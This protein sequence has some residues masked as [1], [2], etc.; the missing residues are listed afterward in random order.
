MERPAGFT[1]EGPAEMYH[2]L[3]T[4]NRMVHTT[5]E[6]TVSYRNH[7]GLEITYPVK[8]IYYS[9]PHGTADNHFSGEAIMNYAGGLGFGLTVTCRRDRFPNGLKPFLHHEKTAPKDQRAKC[10][11]FGKLIVFVKHRWKRL[12]H[13]RHINT[14]M[15]LFS[16]LV[17]PTFLASIIYR[18][19]S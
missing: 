16:P 7:R 14:F 1:A 2:L 6:T 13:Q 9:T 17:P 4:I 8:K 10:M 11:R 12:P 15:F 19:A 3:N 18:H 5:P